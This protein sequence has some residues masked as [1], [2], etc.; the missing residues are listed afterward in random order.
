MMFLIIYL[1]AFKRLGFVPNAT[2]TS[3]AEGAMLLLNCTLFEELNCCLFQ[4]FLDH[5]NVYFLLFYFLF[6]CG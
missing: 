5:S 4:D 2:G 6:L 3:G 1:L